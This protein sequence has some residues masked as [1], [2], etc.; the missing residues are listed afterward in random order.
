M[1]TPDFLFRNC[2]LSIYLEVEGVRVCVR[3]ALMI[4]I[5]YECNNPIFFFFQ[6]KACFDFTKATSMLFFWFLCGTSMS[7]DV[8]VQY[9]K[10][11]LG[12]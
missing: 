5:A 9:Y 4:V 1:G 10:L 11:K 12:S 3:S 2:N 6:R 8:T 7:S